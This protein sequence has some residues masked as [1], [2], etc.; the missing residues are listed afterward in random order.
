[1]TNNPNYTFYHS[2]KYPIPRQDV[3]FHYKQKNTQLPDIKKR[4]SREIKNSHTQKLCNII[5]KYNTVLRSIPFVE[6]IFLCDGITFNANKATSDIDLLFIVKEWYIRRARLA[7]TLLTRRAG[8]KRSYKNKAGKCDCIFYITPSHYNLSSI[9]EREEDVYLAYRIAH[10]VPIVSYNPT[11]INNIYSQNKRIHKIIPNH[12]LKPTISLGL[13]LY[14]QKTKKHK[15]IEKSFNGYLWYVAERLI[16]H[17]RKP[18]VII[19]KKYRK[20]QTSTIIIQD[21]IL[22]FHK[23]KRKKIN[24]TIQEAIK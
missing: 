6:H 8:R 1:M 10:L 9:K 16:K 7:S 18:L 15:I 22:K 23:D 24:N 5:Q 17:I 12:P 3:F 20:H 14:T 11:T 4:L 19:K 13:P 2:M 21:N